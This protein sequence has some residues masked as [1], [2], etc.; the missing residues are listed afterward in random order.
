MEARMSAV[1]VSN[2]GQVVIPA[3]IRRRLNITP[4]SLVEVEVVANKVEIS[5]QQS[6]PATTHASGFGMLRYSG[7]ARKL[8]EF[9]VAQAIKATR[10]RSGK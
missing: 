5:L 7:P 8:S 10:R 1:L 3:A 4:G 6:R 9:D 2:K